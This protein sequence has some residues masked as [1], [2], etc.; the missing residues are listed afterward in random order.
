MQLLSLSRIKCADV[1]DSSQG[2]ELYV[3]LCMKA[4]NQ[5]I[6]VSQLN[7]SSHCID[8]LTG[9]RDPSAPR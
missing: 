5:S 2:Q 4:V 6:G 7:V 8:L 3:N 9:Q 1:H